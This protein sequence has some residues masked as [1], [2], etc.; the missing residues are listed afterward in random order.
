MP[1]GEL[2]ACR[3]GRAAERLRSRIAGA[4]TGDAARHQF[5]HRRRRAHA[6]WRFR[7]ADA[8]LWNDR[9]QSAQRDRRDR[10]RYCARRIGCLG[11]QTCSG[12]C[13]AAAATSASVTSFE[14]QLHPGRPGRSTRAWSSIHSR[15]P[16]RVLRAWRDFTAGAPDDLSVWTVLRKAPPLPVSSC[17]GA[18]HRRR[19]PS[20][21][22]Q[23]RCRSGQ[24]SR[25]PGAAVRRSDR[26]RAGAD[27]LC[28]VPVRLRSAADAGRAQLLEVEQLQHADRCSARRHDRGCRSPSGTGMRDL[29]RPTRW[30]DG[31]CETGGHCT[32]R[33][34]VSRMEP[35]SSRTMT[36]RGT[37]RPASCI[38]SEAMSNSRRGNGTSLAADRD[39]LATR[40]V[41]PH[42]PDGDNIGVSC[43]SQRARGGRVLEDVR[44]TCASRRA[45]S[46]HCRHRHRRRRP[47]SRPSTARS[48]R[49]P[50]SVP[51]ARI[52]THNRSTRVLGV[53]DLRDH[54]IGRG[55]GQRLHG[56]TRL[57]RGH[58][59]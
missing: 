44:R 14:F 36:R 37:T 56:F 46:P 31:A 55:R 23:R 35:H 54:D 15:R 9:R 10:R 33:L 11:A 1:P 29:R 59:P 13:A 19:D 48:R 6:R 47:W 32:P 28:G 3:R 26:D 53:A 5:D 49:A 50:V 52:A 12:L 2:R 21:G 38:R 27:A 17:I 16:T 57:D 40:Q 51:L 25:S 43:P 18:R 45:R 4:R 30:R 42:R 41:E 34:L 22:L 8:P 24:A 20:P 58:D 39:A 7:L